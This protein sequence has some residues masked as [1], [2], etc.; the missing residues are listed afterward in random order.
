M[1]A[2]GEDAWA[3]MRC[4]GREVSLDRLKTCLRLLTLERSATIA[5]GT[6]IHIAVSMVPNRF[7]PVLDRMHSPNRPET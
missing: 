4:R 1:T 6:N 2:T 7:T 3:E 5:A